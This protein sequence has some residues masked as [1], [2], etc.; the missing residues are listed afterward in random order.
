M[1]NLNSLTEIRLQLAF[2]I[3]LELLDLLVRPK[4]SLIPEDRD[5]P[6]WLIKFE[7]DSFDDKIRIVYNELKLNLNIVLKGRDKFR[8]II[9]RCFHFVIRI[10]RFF[11]RFQNSPYPTCFKVSVSC[12]DFGYCLFLKESQRAL[13][14]AR[15]SLHHQSHSEI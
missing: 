10:V 4:L 9:I 1:P 11:I 6:S 3:N 14:F 2:K 8:N 7:D 12:W 15:G 5:R 13:D